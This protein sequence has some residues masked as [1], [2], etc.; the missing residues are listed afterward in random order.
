M[1]KISFEQTYRVLDCPSKF[2]A[3]N[4]RTHGRDISIERTIVNE[5]RHFRS[6]GAVRRAYAAAR[7]DGRALIDPLASRH[8]FNRQGGFDVLHDAHELER[9]DASH[10]DVVFASGARGNRVD[11]RRM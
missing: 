8:D 7:L 4:E 1:R 11:R 9:R 10:A 3:R 6:Y 2:T 5:R